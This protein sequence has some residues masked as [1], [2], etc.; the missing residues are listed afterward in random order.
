MMLI[1]FLKGTGQGDANDA[2][3]VCEYGKSVA[4]SGC[5]PLKLHEI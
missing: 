2:L 5:S 1:E 4:L 3:R